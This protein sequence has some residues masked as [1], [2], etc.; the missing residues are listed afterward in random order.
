MELILHIAVMVCIYAILAT[1]FNLL[2]GFAGLFAFGHA[3]F[4][5]LGAYA[6]ALVALRL[7]MPFPLPLIASVLV[8]GGVGLAVALPSLR[9]SGIYLIIT[10]LALQ[11]IAID[12]IVNWT[13]LTGGPTGLSGVPP[14]SLFGT[15][16]SGPALFLPVAVVAAVACFLVSR[17][18]GDSPFG[19]A[20]RAMRENESAA[21]SV[22]KN[23]FYM[24]V[25]I[26]GV[27]AALASVAG[28]LFAYYL[29]YVGV[30]SFQV[31]ETVLILSMVVVGGT[32]NLVGSVLGAAILVALPEALA[33][34]DLPEG[35]AAQL[36][37][38]IYGCV[39]ILFLVFRP[40][41]LLREPRRNRRLDV[42]SGERNAGDVS[43]AGTAHGVLL[44]GTGLRKRF[45]GITAIA[46]LDIQLASGR[47]TG[48]V[49]PNG[50]GKT[51]AFNL[52]TGF[53]Q[54]DGGEIRYKGKLL[55]RLRPHELV[56]AGLARS[57][58]DLRLFTGMSVL[59]N[60]LVALPRQ[61]GDRLLMLFLRPLL[62]RREDARNARRA[63]AI[64]DFIGLR[65]RAFDLADDLSYAEEKLL[66]VA[67]LVATE[68]EVLLFDEP[69]SGLDATAMQKIIDLLRRL[70][71]SNKAICIIEHNLEAIR[72][73]CDHL[74]Y[75]DEGRALAEGDP[76]ALM[77]DP[78]LIRRYF[79]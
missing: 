38:L 77:R 37:L 21:A 48:L 36:R 53:L 20:L 64:L 13:S 49:G 32:G 60:V 17:H 50:A 73:A 59:E 57:F 40:E 74:I 28:S 34:V 62:V 3:V 25:S 76:E 65:D 4:Y 23:I 72:T 16:I 24:K 71:S 5:A 68:A 22:G 14:L 1:S 18:I 70:A 2:I 66:V 46:S 35:M 75:L 9:I 52:L 44:E 10:T 61:Q 54:A 7:H 33:F 47:I 56:R 63:M 42:D 29:S 58:Q 69:L 26:F 11:V 12:V 51:T 45:G 6:T 55:H 78:D 15:P 8:T 19:R 30:D 79:Q 27:S 41:G 31:T 39:L 43:V 67:R